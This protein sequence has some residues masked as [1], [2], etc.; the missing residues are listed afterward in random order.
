MAVNNVVLVGR[1][2]TD[3]KISMISEDVKQA[4]F[5][6]AV[7]RR[8][9]RR[10]AERPDTDFIKVNAT[11]SAAEFAEK[12]F[13]KGKQVSVVGS[14]ETYSYQHEDRTVYDF[15]VKADQL[16]FADSRSGNSEKSGNSVGGTETGSAN[17][18]DFLDESG[19]APAGSF[20]SDDLPF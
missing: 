18:L 19:F 5:S 3:V 4:K 13:T 8:Y 6:I 20:D 15:C 7:D 12:Y 14:I 1:L 11:R 9:K 2:S 17:A 16:G 10:G